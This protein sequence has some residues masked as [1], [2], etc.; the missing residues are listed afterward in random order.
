MSEPFILFLDLHVP[1]FMRRVVLFN[2]AHCLVG[3]HYKCSHNRCRCARGGRGKQD[4]GLA[5]SEKRRDAQSMRTEGGTVGHGTPFTARSFCAAAAL[6]G[7]CL[8]PK[9]IAEEQTS[10]MLNISGELYVS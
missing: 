7:T 6:I 5:D 1:P 4:S 2:A 9:P 8:G 3:V 10:K